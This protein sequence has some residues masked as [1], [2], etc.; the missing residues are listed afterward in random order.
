[1]KQLFNSGLFGQKF[2]KS[3]VFKFNVKKILDESR[4]GEGSSVPIVPTVPLFHCSPDPL[5]YCSSVP[6]VPLFSSP[7]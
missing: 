2:A 1:M 5:V 7:L 6:T 3:S 4:S